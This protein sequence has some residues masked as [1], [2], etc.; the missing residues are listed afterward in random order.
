MQF[1]KLAQLRYSVRKFDPRPV[2]D[3]K[4]QAILQA[5]QVAPSAKNKQSWRVLVL[6]DKAALERLKECTPCHYHAP[7]AFL[8]CY[9]STDTYIRE[10]DGR[11][12][13]VIDAAIAGTHMMLEA[14]DIGIGSTWVMNFDVDALREI[15][16][17]PTQI[18]PVALL[19]CGY[20]HTNVT[21]NSRHK[22]YK[23]LDNLCVYNDYGA[24]DTQE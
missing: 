8:V 7:L 16:H 17:I 1:D 11:S 4:I 15:Y 21:I 3:K 14:C 22:E 24:V 12:S 6:N 23:S 13:G 19:V 20:P 10:S 18:E 5:A 9:D 2:E